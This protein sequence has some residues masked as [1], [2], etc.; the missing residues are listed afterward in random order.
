MRDCLHRSDIPGRLSEN[1]LAVLLPQTGQGTPAAAERIAQL[2]SQ[3]AEAP[4][5]AGF[6]CYSDDGE[7]ASDLLKIATDRSTAAQPT[8]SANQ[9]EAGSAGQRDLVHR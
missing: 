9:G 4:V 5:G 7:R 6:A 1:A 2:L 8:A 3:V